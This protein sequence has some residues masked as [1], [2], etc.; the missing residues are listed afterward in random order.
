VGPFAVLLQQY[1]QA[2][3]LSQEELAERAGLSA[4]GISDLERGV[5][6]SPYP[7]TVRALAKALDLDATAQTRLLAAVRPRSG[8]PEARGSTASLPIPL[9]SFVGRECE[10][11]EVRR[12]LATTRL[13]TLTGPGGVGKTRLA[14]AVAGDE[15]ETFPDGVWFVD[16][17]PLAEPGLVPQ[18]V[19][20]ALGV[21]QQP[22]RPMLEALADMLRARRMLLVLDNCEHLLPAC[23]ELAD[24]L[25]RTCPDL[26][27]LA[28]S[29]AVLDV[30]GEIAWPVPS[31]GL[32]ST[33]AGP[34]AGWAAGSEAVRLFVERA[35]AAAPHFEL[36]DGNASAV[37]TI[38]RRLD[39]LP[40]AIELAATRVR[41]LA[42]QQIVER[43]D[44]AL[45]LLVTGPRT[46]P[47]RLQT[48]RAALDW[49]YSL[50]SEPDRRLFERLAVFAGGWD[51]E[52]AE[53]V[54]AGDGIQTG[55]ILDAL[56]RLVD[57]SMV[58]AEPSADQTVRFR[59]LEP[60]R[61]YAGERL[62]VRD[63]VDLVQ[64]RHA[65]YYTALVERIGTVAWG[66]DS[67]GRRATLEREY[68]NV[69]AALRWL[70]ARGEADAA[71]R[72]GSTLMSFWQLT[73]RAGEGRAWLDEI[74][75]LPA[76]TARTTARVRALVA[77]GRLA[78]ELGDFR[79]A[80]SMLE[81]GHA[82]ARALGDRP[83]VVEVLNE[84]G[85]V[86]LFRRE[87][88]LAR[89]LAEEGLSIS[90]TTGQR[91]MEGLSCFVIAE[92][93]YLLGDPAAVALAERALGI[94]TDVEF[95]SV[96]SIALRTLG[97]IHF[98]RGDFPTARALFERGL[99]AH[100]PDVVELNQLSILVHLGWVATE[101]GDL[102]RAKSWLIQ[103]LRLAQQNFG[104][105]RL[106]VPLEG[107]AQVAAASGQPS[108]ALRLAGAAAALRETHAVRPTPTEHAQLERW[109]TR[110]RANLGQMA[111]H[112]AW[113]TG[114]QLTP[115]KAVAEALA[116]E[117]PSSSIRRAPVRSRSDALTAREREVALL[118]GEGL[119]TREIAARLVIAEG[120]ARVHIERI[121]A[122]LDLHSRTQLAARAATGQL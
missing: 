29:R 121:L 113:A 100:P 120:T 71:Q 42:P 62:G 80:Q 32:P 116:L 68:G 60:P 1:R 99:A 108:S 118:V 74:L 44:D 101:E 53:A 26:T 58:A 20:S 18:G 8:V 4:R 46:A 13:L 90:Q 30:A 105:A 47:A 107:L 33:H 39:G 98:V 45:G 77:A 19:A 5:R 84:L 41:A 88:A 48:M 85:I 95:P 54:C 17:A 115:E 35:R 75:S 51:L 66:P 103:A 24:T 96:A 117:V 119:G 112:S 3:G 28:T 56:T 50:L 91:A 9:S 78:I 23:A 57:Q 63:E 87:F 49:S 7:V 22:G 27:I 25:L 55:E 64:R 76:G 111:V 38:C 67:V 31:L 37:A 61:Q 82:L 109:L 73:G 43:L 10:I 12:L 52:A 40:L 94:L 110:A 102:P 86:A 79:V 36:D 114:R 83:G 72:L 122:K 70:V 14:L 69:R 92:A 106:V 15:L 16:L 21:R 81:E 34:A 59:L 97:A 104:R 6:R 65:N 11:A 2:A 89:A 93:A